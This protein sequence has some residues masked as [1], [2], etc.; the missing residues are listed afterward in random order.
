ML[1]DTPPSWLILV[2]T[3][4]RTAFAWFKEFVDMLFGFVAK[5]APPPPRMFCSD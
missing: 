1:C 3:Y 5:F 2:S 4:E